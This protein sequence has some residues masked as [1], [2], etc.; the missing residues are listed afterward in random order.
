M[1]PTPFDL[2]AAA[3]LQREAHRLPDLSGCTV[4]LPHP[5]V[6][7]PLQAALRRAI[8]APVFLPPRLTTLS[9][10][11]AAQSANGEVEADSLRL[12]QL[13]DALAE[14]GLFRDQALWTAAAELLR[15]MTEL[16]GHLLQADRDVAT[17][18]RQARRAYAGRTNR[19]LDA[20]SQLVFELW[21]AM[22]QGNQTDPMVDYARRLGRAAES[23][24]G[25]LYTLGLSGLTPLEQ[26][27]IAAWA[28]RQPLHALAWQPALP[29]RRSLLDLVWD[30]PGE[31]VPLADRARQAGRV[32]PN[33]P[34]L[35]GVRLHGAVDLEGQCRS[36]AHAIAA[37]LVQGMRHIAIVAV[38]RMAARRLRA[39]L[40]RQSILVQDETGW[41]VSTA[42]VA[43]V[44][45]RLLALRQDDAYYQDLLDLLKSPFV[46]HDLE[47]G[48]RLQA[49]AGLEAA[50][51]AQGVATGWQRHMQLARRQAPAALPLLERL[52]RA[53]AALS[54]G[55]CRLADWQSRLLAALEHIGAVDALAA[56]TAGRQLLHL[57]ETLG[58]EV[59]A[60]PAAYPWSEWREWLAQRLEQC[61]FR[62]TDIVSPVRLIP[63]QDARLRDFQAALL[64]G[65][66][67]AHLPPRDGQALFNDALRRELGLPTTEQRHGE[68]RGA[69]D[70]LLCQVP[71]VLCT[72]QAWSGSEANPPSPWLELLEGFHRLAYGSSL[73]VDEG[74]ALDWAVAQGSA[75]IRPEP[76][77]AR[78]PERLSASAWQSLVDCPYRYYA[79]HL[80][81]LGELEVVPEEMEKRDY[82]ERVH[83]ILHDFHARHPRLADTDPLM[84]RD[85]LAQISGREFDQARQQSY[86]ALGWQLRWERRL[87][88][89][90][91][92][93]VAW[94]RQGYR[95]RSGEARL[96][97]PLEWAAGQGLL[98]HGRADRLD[99]GPQGPAVLDYKT[100]P[101]EALRSRLKTPGEDVQLPFYALLAEAAQAAYVA[102]DDERVAALGL[103]GDLGEAADREAKRIAQTMAS[104]ARG[105][106]LPAQGAVAT[107]VHCE[108][109]GLC[110]RD[111]WP[112]Q[113][114]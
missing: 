2:A 21:H 49:V 13:H 52:D 96:E 53:R 1:S 5:H 109:R 36:A 7:A 22:G 26:S 106:A 92:W 25:P 87:A 31:G 61:T 114:A 29:E 108:M 9:L 81:R 91:E 3:L 17:L 76:R 8:S 107:C 56:D 83:A 12:V 58:R 14:T 32:M 30:A 19:A 48:L 72:W 74:G 82:G 40:E 27:C 15:L 6:A 88:A 24:A 20:E 66:D 94:E 33:S 85:D 51:R 42:S 104:M 86:L 43:H 60:H 78:L 47:D 93:A 68:L 46:F 44:L 112:D 16:S 80:L 69:L 79:R 65:A 35:P 73:R 4:L 89:Y 59:S 45:D 111:Y 105:D 64:I 97:R 100:R 113:T 63:L 95:W 110:R 70:E 10:L 18:R 11:A 77:P 50:I 55:R 101:R 54:A 67:A 57:L 71:E 99:D 75:T 28:R 90:V 41:T 23:A 98:L 102:L 38:D 37:W 39:L 84:L 34:L 103:E 62:D